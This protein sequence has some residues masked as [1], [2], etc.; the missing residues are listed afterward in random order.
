M[1]KKKKIAGIVPCAGLSRRMGA[2]KPLLPFGNGTMISGTV[3]S[4]LDAGVSK[5]IVAAGYRA[6]EIEEELASMSRTVIIHNDN[7]E[8]GDMMESVQLGIAEA[9]SFDGIVVV[10][11]DMPVIA[12]KTFQKL[13]TWF[14]AS[15]AS[16]VIPCSNGHRIHPPVISRECFP[17]LLRFSEGGGLRRALLHFLESTVLVTVDDD[18]GCMM[19]TD[20]PQ[21]YVRLM[22]YYSRV[23]KRHGISAD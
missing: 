9:Q 22:E 10:P 6:D 11:G 5:V 23:R 19:D 7:F 16:V 20:T 13:F 1:M 12:Q 18:P 4:L 21:D 2:F 3:K 17:Y 15:E 8:H 14:G